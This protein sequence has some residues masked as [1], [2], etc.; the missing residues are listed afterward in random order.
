MSSSI[1]PFQEVLQSKNGAFGL[2]EDAVSLASTV[3][4]YETVYEDDAAI[5]LEAPLDGDES[6]GCLPEMPPAPNE[7]EDESELE[8]MLAMELGSDIDTEAD[9]GDE[10]AAA[11]GGLPGILEGDDNATED[12]EGGGNGSPPDSF[13]E[14]INAELHMTT[15]RDVDF[16]KAAIRAMNLDKLSQVWTVASSVPNHIRGVEEV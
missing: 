6:S 12:Q 3:P 1:S 15:Q 4:D 16:V 9:T 11:A 14:Q 5:I 7:S 13:Q 10:E 2:E 8:L